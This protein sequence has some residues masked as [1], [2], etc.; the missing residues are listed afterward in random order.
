MTESRWA[1]P[2]A[3][4]AALGRRGL[5]VGTLAGVVSAAG[6]VAN[7]AQFYRSY[8]VAFVFVLGIA[9]GSLAIS[10]LHHMSGGAWGLVIRRIL[11]ASAR[12]LPIVALFA[13]P[14]LF[15]LG[16]LYPWADPARVAGDEILR[17]RARYM[18]PTFFTV[19]LAICLLLWTVLAQALSRLSKKQDDS[20]APGLE[21]RMQ[22]VA[23]PGLAVYC[24]LVTIAS[25]DL[26][27]SL[28]PHWYSAIYGVYVVGGQAISGLAFTLLVSLFLVRV[29]PMRGVLQPRHVHDHG[30]LLLAFTM[31][32]AY[33]ALSQ[34]LIIWSGNLPEE[35]G[36]FHDRLRGGWG[37]ISLFLALFH[38][39]VPFVFLLSR[40]FKRDI[41]KLAGAAGLLLFMRW[42]DLFWL[43]SPVFHPGRLSVHWLDLTTPIALFGLWLAVFARELGT[44]SL[45]PANDPNLAVALEAH[46]HG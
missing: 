1:P 30:N 39:A 28:D 20:P 13:V 24:L 5:V 37:A 10:M 26:L 21:R 35:I 32:W 11:E 7:P 45:L 23:A 19:R 2:L 22:L 29:G 44:R 3:D 38:F 9:L 42:V 41:G 4:L 40:D 46:A 12:T 25:I 33:F 31:L 16:H 43:V 8:L 14:L 6:L 36:F 17:H 15:G 27:M 18:N 34:F